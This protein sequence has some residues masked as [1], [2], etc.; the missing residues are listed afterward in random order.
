MI[1][2]YRRES[3]HDLWRKKWQVGSR[4]ID[5]RKIKLVKNPCEY[6]LSSI[7]DL[8]VK[9]ATQILA[10]KLMRKCRADEVL[11]PVV[12]LAT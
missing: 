2:I 4:R 10:G 3:S 9:V 6:T 12:A 7:C 5:E 11:V 1:S 8:A